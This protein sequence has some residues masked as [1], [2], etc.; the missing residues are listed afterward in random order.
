MAGVRVQLMEPRWHSR[1][2]LS[3]ASD[4]VPPVSSSSF[5]SPLGYLPASLSLSLPL[6]IYVAVY[7]E[8]NLVFC[9]F[10]IS[11]FGLSQLPP[12]Y[13]PKTHPNAPI[14]HLPPASL[15]PGSYSF[16]PS[17]SSA[18]HH[19]NT[20]IKSASPASRHN[21]HLVTTSLGTCSPGWH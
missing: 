13:T 1:G 4:S 20:P 14:P 9:L 10:H 18:S 3:S 2:S 8:C 7:Y 19:L 15:P 17:R 16:T 21:P 6:S 11:I 5:L 12:I